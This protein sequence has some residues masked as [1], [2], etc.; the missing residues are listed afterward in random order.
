MI[1]YYSFIVEVP[2]VIEGLVKS[3][4]EP[5]DPK[6]EPGSVDAMDEPDSEQA[7]PEMSG[8]PP[9]HSFIAKKA[10]TPAVKSESSY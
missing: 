10:W 2:D 9:A 1:T 7:D 6:P 8:T 4:Y 5:T 3:S